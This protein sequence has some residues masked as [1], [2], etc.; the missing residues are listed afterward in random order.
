MRPVQR[1][2]SRLA[3][4]F[5]E[6]EEI[7]RGVVAGHSIRSIALSLGRSPSTV[8]REGGPQL[9]EAP[10]FRAIAERLEICSPG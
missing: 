7:S 8:S 1:R 4:M 6:R 2:R 3:P 10:G 9:V 5:S